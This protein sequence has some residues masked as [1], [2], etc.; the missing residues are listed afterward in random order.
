MLDVGEV[1]RDELGSPQG[2][3]VAE[4]DDRGVSD[5][6]RSGAVDAADDLP[7][8]LDRQRFR[9]G[10][11]ALLALLVVVAL[12]RRNQCSLGGARRNWRRLT[13]AL[14]I[15][16]ATYLLLYALTTWL[17]TFA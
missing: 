8:L 4:Q 16:V 7:D 5:P 14:G 10:G 13:L 6:V 17:G 15:A 9:L 12:R 2:G 3:G 11:L 1:E